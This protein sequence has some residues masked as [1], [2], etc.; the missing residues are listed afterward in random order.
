MWKTA[1]KACLCCS[2]E[3]FDA[4]CQSC[5]G[6]ISRL[7]GQGFSLKTAAKSIFAVS[8][9]YDLICEQCG[10]SH[11]H[12]G[13]YSSEFLQGIEEWNLISQRNDNE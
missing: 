9:D 13:M 4:V 12:A 1:L 8:R 7:M 10:Q 11:W 6:R 5:E 2:G 3:S